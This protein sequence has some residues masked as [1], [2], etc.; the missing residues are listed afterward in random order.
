MYYWFYI[1]I[2]VRSSSCGKFMFSQVSVILSG[3]DPLGRH[4]LPSRHP[5]GQTPL[6]SRHTPGQTPHPGQTHPGQTPLWE[7]TPGRHPPGDGTCSG[8]YASYWNGFLFKYIVLPFRLVRSMDLSTVTN[9]VMW[10]TLMCLGCL[11]L[12]LTCPR[13]MS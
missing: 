9:T 12:S 8:W 3:R 4:P 2:T 5:S 6:L 1:V 13:L 7:D 10:R 11:L